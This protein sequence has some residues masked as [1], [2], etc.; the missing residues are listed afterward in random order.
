MKILIDIPEEIYQMCKNCLGDADIIE[1]AIA[2]GI[3]QPDTNEQS[4]R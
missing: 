3:P 4:A 1:S 2:S